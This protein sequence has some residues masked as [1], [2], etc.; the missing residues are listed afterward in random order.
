LP[1]NGSGNIN[2]FTAI[3]NGTTQQI[4]LINVTATQSG[5]SSTK[6][7]RIIV[8][9]RPQV[10]VNSPDICAGQSVTLTVTGA[11]DNINWSPATGLNITT[12]STVIANPTVTTNYS[13]NASF[14]STGCF[15]DITSR[16]TVKPVPSITASFTNPTS[17]GSLTGSITI[18]GLQNSATYTLQYTRNGVVQTPVPRTSSASGTIVISNLT[19]GTYSDISVI[20]NGCASNIVGPFVLTDPSAPAQPAVTASSPICAGAT[21]SLNVTTPV[22][23]ATYIWSGPNSFNQT[24]SVS[25]VSIPNA[26]TAATGTYSVIVR[27]NNCN[28]VAGTVAV[29]VN[30]RPVI[31]VNSGAICAGNSIDLTASGADT[32]SWSPGTALNT[33]TGPT[34]TASPTANITYTVTGVNTTTGCSNTA[35]STVTVRPTPV[36]TGDFISPTSC[37][38]SNGSITIRGLTA[39]VTYTW[40]YQ[41]NG[42][43]Q[44]G[45]Q[46]AGASGTIVIASL[47]SGTYSNIFVVLNTCP[48]N[49]IGP[50]E[51]REPSAPQAPQVT[52]NSPLCSGNTLTLTVQ[53]PVSGATYIWSGPNSFNQTTT[54]PTVSITNAGV[55]AS[56]VYSVTVVTNNCPS[57]PGIV[58]VVV[59]PTPGGPQVVTPVIYC[60]GDI[61]GP[62]SATPDNGNTLLWYTAATGGT[63]SGTAPTPSTASIGTVT[64]YVSQ[65]TPE[66]CEGPRVP[67]SVTVR[68]TPSIDNQNLT[69]CTGTSFSFQPLGTPGGTTFTWSIPVVTGG[70]TGGQ[71]GSGITMSGNLI[72][73]TAQPQTATY[74]VTPQIGNCPGNP[75]TFVVTVNPKPAINNLSAEICSGDLFTVTPSATVPGVILPAGTTYTWNTPVSVPAGAVTGGVSQSIGQTSISQTL[76]N[77]T[78]APAVL[79]YQVTPVSVP[80]GGCAGAPFNVVVKVNPRPFIPLQTTTICSGGTFNI[81]PSNGVSSSIVP[82]NTMYTWSTPVSNPSGAITGGS[83]QTVPQPSISQTL[84]NTTVSPA[85]ITYTVTPVSGADGNCTGAPFEVI[86]TVNPQP[87]I[88]NLATTICSN[89]EF[90]IAPS[91]VPANTT[92]TWGL[93]VSTPAGAVTG[94]T[95]QGVPQ[96]SIRQRLVNITNVPAV[97]TYTV[98]PSS[99]SCGNTPFELVVTVNP[100][101]KIPAQA[102]T[103]CTGSSFTVNPGHNPPDVLLP[104]GT[105]YT[106]AL[107]VVSPAGA[108]T[109]A[110]SQTTPTGS[111]TQTLFNNTDAQAFVTYT[112]I[113]VSGAAGNCTGEPFTITT[114]VNPDAKAAVKVINDT[115]CYPFQITSA[116]L[117]NISPISASDRYEWYANNVL[118]GTSR[119]FPGYTITNPGDSIRIKL[120]A[121]SRYGCKPDSVIRTFYTKLKPDAS[122]TI[123]SGGG[124]GPVTISFVNTSTF[125]PSFKY[126]WDFGN[127]Q[128]STQYQPS[129][130]VFLPNPNF[131]DTIYTVRLLAFNECDTITA[132][133][134]ISVQS[135]PQSRFT[136]SK[137]V[138][139]SPM[140]VTFNNTSRGVNNTYIWDFGD[141]TV[142]TTVQATPVSHTYFS[143]LR[144]TFLV[145]LIAVNPCGSDTSQFNIVVTPNTIKLDFAVNG[146]EQNGCAPHTVR[147]INNSSGATLFRWDFGDG[148]IL[149]TTRNRD[150]VV[151]TFLSPGTYTV[152]LAASNSCSDTSA[153]E[154]INVFGKPVPDFEPSVF[155]ACIGDSVQFKNNTS[156]GATSFL[157]KFGDGATSV[158]STPVH[159][160]NRPG[161]YTVTLVAYKNNAPGSICLDS[162]RKQITIVDSLPVDFTMS[163]DFGTCAP[164]KVKFTNTFRGYATLLWDFGDGTTGTGDV[165][166]HEYLRTGVYYPRLIITTTGGCVYSGRKKVEL[167]SPEGT[168][169]VQTGFNC[170]SRSVRFEAVPQNTDSV[171]W[172]FGD[173]NIL[174]TKD[175]VVFH[176]YSNPGTYYASA[177]FKSAGGCVFSVPGS[178]EIK[179]D[180]VVPGFKVERIQECGRT[181]VKFTD[182]SNVFFGKQSVEWRLGDGGSA[183]GNVVTNTYNISNTYL[184]Q[185]IIRGNSGCTDTLEV[186]VGVFVRSV[187]AAQITFPDPVCTASDINFKS[188]IQSTDRITSYNWQFSN[189]AVSDQK[190][191][192]MKFANTGQYSVRFITGTEFGCFDTVLST[193]RVN[194]TPA[195]RAVPDVTICRGSSVTL[196]ASGAVSYTWY[197]SNGLS[198]ISCATTIATPLVT[199]PYTVKGMTREGCFSYDTLLVSVI[200]PFKMR[201]E[202]GDSIC[203]GESLQLLASGAASFKWTPAAGLNRD[204][205]PNPVARPSFTTRYR[206]VGSD[207]ARCFTDTAFVTVGVGQYPTVNL[208]PDQTLATGTRLNL[209]STITNGPIE[210]WLWTPSVNLSCSTCPL[211][212]ATI[213]KDISYA[214]KV[215]NYF[216]CSASDTINIKVFC[217]ESQVYIP[218]AFSPDGD[219]K[220]DVFMVRSSGIMQVKSLRVFNRWGELVFE[221][222]NILPNDPA[223][224]WD[225]R[226]RGVIMGPDVYAYTVEV[227]CDNGIPYFYKGN[228][229]LLR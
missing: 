121:I 81:T 161:T 2:S 228:V 157:W 85:T 128:T 189:G 25:S 77:T 70:L 115:A 56:G 22:A 198:C 64:Y 116:V 44:T 17:C 86:V 15:T 216:G 148:N 4:A 6:N 7:F 156:V 10:T 152:R 19:A 45:T 41:K 5:C 63:G 133:E 194:P 183:S 178:F 97:M 94:G 211:P 61:A 203:I 37:G 78:N 117:S 43:P 95:A 168:V 143:G 84:I 60:Q 207:E 192:T 65:I 103:I 30:P 104:F 13:I 193:F 69:V 82:S 93:P 131:G 136:P 173:G 89:S 48:S 123:S 146:I 210:K 208:G 50:F 139:C 214:V 16:V 71:A 217:N 145:K 166:E 215:T 190:D 132:T 111:I 26:T 42:V 80:N 29:V 187:P 125:K 109:G 142:I 163:A 9:P 57:L 179:I 219:G 209:T 229:T 224:G 162:I 150:T 220:N 99:G 51:L 106:W 32:Y 55:A 212:I 119:D 102:V 75:F 205:V 67:V 110:T 176:K 107:P 174:R 113:P 153:T 188:I 155:S 151:H 40:N 46:I 68:A 137:T 120:V 87:A 147:F 62:L 58:N 35:V 127:G 90:N 196:S 164:F 88:G 52:S 195:V 222:T 8:N 31:T 226:I 126:F 105:T 98:T 39:G 185:Q 96:S 54:V 213:K 23:G 154:V 130:V 169:R 141:G 201:V 33:T 49:S 66:G 167:V 118:I 53:T 225:G 202:P 3:N 134:L 191:V 27:L 122:F 112:I 204:D 101:P 24:T 100:A 218:N 11:A 83:A 140:V 171:I 184:V 1:A 20:L 28:S 170:E 91:N 149:S 92:Y 59:N 200:Q 129:P 160:Y 197:P 186:P 159:R 144:D 138:G 14:S 79:T 18:S 124:C 21:L 73:P 12:G 114:T 175:R 206:V 165:V 74:T 34:V 221:K 177:Q 36:I 38:A 172:N 223:S 227:V 135:K 108:V 158:L 181:L 182:T 199:T 47:S 76:I 72:N 180:K